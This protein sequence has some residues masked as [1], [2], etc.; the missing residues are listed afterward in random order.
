MPNPFDTRTLISHADVEDQAQI[1]TPRPKYSRKER[2]LLNC[3]RVNGQTTMLT[4]T[5][6]IFH[7]FRA[8]MKRCS[9]SHPA[10]KLTLPKAGPL[11]QEAKPRRDSLGYDTHFGPSALRLE[12]SEQG[13]EQAQFLYKPYVSK[14]LTLFL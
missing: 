12:T 3:F 5:A 1:A 8:V 13:K 11:A 2:S 10:A 14:K 4:L 6:F 9:S 7:Y